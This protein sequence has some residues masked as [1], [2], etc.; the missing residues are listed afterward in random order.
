MKGGEKVSKEE[1]YNEPDEPMSFPAM[2]EVHNEAS[3]DKFKA[4][5]DFKGR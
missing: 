5:G 3:D 1:L 2:D 4:D